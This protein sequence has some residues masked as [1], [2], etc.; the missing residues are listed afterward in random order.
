MRYK[1][2]SKWI[3]NARKTEAMQR[4]FSHCE[5]E[6][7][8]IL[9]MRVRQRIFQGGLIMFEIRKKRKT[10]DDGTEITTY[11]RDVCNANAL[12]VEAGT[13]G[14]K[15]G[16]TGHGC[17]TYFRIE[18]MYSTDIAVRPLG[19]DND[20]GFEVVLGGDCELETVICA[21]KFITKVL[22][23]ESTETFH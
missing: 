1:V 14:Y 10:L 6:N 5:K 13:T 20:K 19:E 22:E 8:V 23:D 7:L 2:Q 3:G 21:L 12:E 4:L 18:D 15:G 11:S 9:M 16:D 17:R